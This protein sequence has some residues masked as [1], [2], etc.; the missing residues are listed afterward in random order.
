MAPAIRREKT[1]TPK[2][3]ALY[4]YVKLMRHPQHWYFTL[5]RCNM[6]K[7][8]AKRYRRAKLNGDHSPIMFMPL[9]YSSDLTTSVMLADAFTSTSLTWVCSCWKQAWI[10]FSGTR[11]LQSGKLMS[12]MDTNSKMSI[13]CCWELYH[14]FFTS[15]QSFKMRKASQNGNKKQ[16]IKWYFFMF[17]M[18]F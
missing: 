6:Q 14:A 2:S 17:R 10:R 9:M 16:I 7:I 3:S 8:S 13:P 1:L 18:A 11:F 12:R 5:F 4:S 15:F